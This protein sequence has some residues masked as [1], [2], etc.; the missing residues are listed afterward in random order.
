MSARIIPRG[1][2]LI[3]VTIGEMINVV[4]R[5]SLS[6][7][8]IP[9]ARAND[10]WQLRAARGKFPPGTFQG[11]KDTPMANRERGFS[12]VELFVVSAIVV[13]IIIAIPMVQ[14]VSQDYRIVSDARGI[15]AQ[16]ALAR[17]RAAAEFTRAEVNFDTSNNTY[18]VEVWN[19]STGAFVAEGGAQYLSQGD[20]FGYGTLTAAAAGQSPMAQTTQITFN[21]RGFPVTS[22]GALTSNDVIYFYNSYGSY[23]AVSVS[24]AGEPEV[25]RYNG[26]AW[27]QQW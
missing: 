25:W 3:V 24:I 14:N 4:L 5:A 22:T 8:I 10:S 23:G 11:R 7:S 21:S 20:V 9:G 26:S 1:S 15:A 17:M 6:N 13:L 2:S 12:F 27:V 18:Q 16:L 19:K